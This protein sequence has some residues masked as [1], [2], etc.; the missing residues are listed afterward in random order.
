[1]VAV[2]QWASPLDLATRRRRESGSR[3][4][5]IG[6]RTVGSQ[7]VVDPNPERRRG[8]TRKRLDVVQERDGRRADGIA[9][10]AGHLA[11]CPALAAGG[12]V[13]RHPGHAR[14]GRCHGY[15][16]ETHLHP[17]R[18]R[19]DEDEAYCTSEHKIEHPVTMSRIGRLR[20]AC[21]QAYAIEHISHSC[22]R[23]PRGLKL[24]SSGHQELRRDAKVRPGASGRKKCGRDATSSGVRF[25]RRHIGMNRVSAAGG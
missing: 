3:R 1:M 2:S 15:W 7:Q 21:D 11:R 5:R 4:V 24:Q 12:A 25:Q 10:R 6:N 18:K 17:R 9:I 16:H 14:I 19:Q 23:R 13:R 22:R 20:K 8:N